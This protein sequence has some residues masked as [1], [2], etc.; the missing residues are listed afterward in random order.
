MMIKTFEEKCRLLNYQLYLLHTILKT[1]KET[2]NEERILDITLTALTANGALGLSRAA[3]FYYDKEK[4]ILYGKKGIGPFNGE[5]AAKIW[6]SLS[7]EIPLEEYFINN[8]EEKFASQ[9]FPQFIKNIVIDFDKLPEDNYFKRAIKEK[10]ITHLS[11]ISEPSNFPEEIRSIFV[12]CEIIIIPLFSSRDVLGIIMADNAFHYKPIDESTILFISLL[13]IQT[14][15]ALENASNYNIVQQQLEELKE[16]HNAMQHLQEEM[17][18]QERLSTIGKMASYFLHEIKNP[19]VTIGGFAKRMSEEKDLNII[20]RD[21]NIIFKEIKKMEHILNKLTTFTFLAPLRIE[22][23]NLMDV[24]KEVLEF[25]ELEFAKK[26]IDVQ[27]DI[28]EDISLKAERV[29]IFEILFNLIS[30]SAESMNKGTIKISAGIENS[31][32]RLS[33]EDTGKGISSEDLPHITEP[34]FSTKHNG[35]GLGLFIVSNIV[36]NYG[37][38]LEITSVEQKGTNVNIYLPV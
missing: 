20:R 7:N 6:T 37:G 10:E 36:E 24:V 23:L 34:F 27:I 4:N 32:L 8:I 33:V 14:G 12:P 13:S 15:I 38:K 2:F 17:I 19:L 35:F 3:I 28:P 26:H 18:E 5:E 16:L 31:F 30:N 9:Q 25:F 1:I 21:A 29:Q 11:N 22:R